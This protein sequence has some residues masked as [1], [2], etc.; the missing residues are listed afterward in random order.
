MTEQFSNWI[1]GEPA[2]STRI[3][4]SINPSDT[5]EVVGHYALASVEDAGRAIAAAKAAA[6]A[7]A[8]SAPQLRHDILKRA[9]D[10]IL[11]R[12]AELGK[13]LARE[14]GKTLPE[15]TGEVGRAAQVMLY[16]AGEALRSSGEKF[17][18]LAADSEIDVVHEP[19]GVIGI[20]TPWN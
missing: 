13:L 12:Q 1:G 19:V 10:E 17:M 14:E 2:G 20:V 9:S 18:G 3:L 15:A 8:A 5:R 4:D 11:A 7:W 6:P 16:M